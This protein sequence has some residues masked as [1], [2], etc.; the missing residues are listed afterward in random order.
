MLLVAHHNVMMLLRNLESTQL[1]LKQLLHFFH[2]LQTSLM[3]HNSMIHAKA[4][5]NIDNWSPRWTWHSFFG[6]GSS[7]IYSILFW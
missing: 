6:C 5:T 4:W 3:H 1:S 7:C 2:A